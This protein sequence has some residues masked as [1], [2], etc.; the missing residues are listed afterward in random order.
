[1]GK[2]TNQIDEQNETKASP[3]ANI[4]QAKKPAGKKRGLIIAGAVVLVLALGTGAYAFMSRDRGEQ[5]DTGQTPK[6][7]SVTSNADENGLVSSM[8]LECVPRG[9]DN[10]RTNNTLAVDPSNTNIVYVG[11]EYKGVY[12]STDGG[13]TWKQSD[14]GI[15]G[16]AMQSDKTKKCIQELG[17][18][19]IDSKDPK[20]LLVSR[21]ESPG[22]LS[23]KFSENAGVWE[24]HDSGASWKQIVQKGMNA[25]GSR[26]IAFDP[27]DSNIIYY[28]INNGTPSFTDANGQKMDKLYNKE[29]ILYQTNDG[30]KVWR[31]LPTGADKGL[32]ALNVGVDSSDSKKLWLFSFSESAQGGTE[33]GDKQKAVLTSTD[34]GKS[35]TSL[36]DKLPP[37]YRTLA[38]GALSPKNG[39]IAFVTTQTRQGSPKSFTTSNGG[40][41]WS[42][43]NMY[44]EAADFDP[45]DSTGKRL[46]G[47][48]PYGS[49]PS[50][51]ESRDGGKTWTQLSKVPAEVDGQE[52]GVRISG[53]AF[54]QSDKN[55]VY[56]SGSS[57]YVWKSTDNGK[58]WKVVMDLDKI[59]GANKNAQGSTKS[60]E[61]DH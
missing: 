49:T 44:I 43:S 50:I 23:T 10:Y 30:G 14:K 38:G 39:Q 46:L 9:H 8:D 34:G 18:T 29:G 11:V 47:Y 15:R 40:A 2:S 61:Q 60:S 4:G 1:M 5:K 37:G 57:G 16:Y 22:D 45:N 3:E 17:R 53:F 27:K 25:S 7:S 54:S 21:V 13:E 41:S 32:R 26:A 24:S 31:E 55:V 12:K 28:G 19:I 52:N 58:T 20:H 51:V 59:G 33:S 36:A 6:E 48:A 35:W 42:E 56:M